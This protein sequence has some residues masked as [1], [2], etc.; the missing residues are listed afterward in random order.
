MKTWLFR[1]AAGGHPKLVGLEGGRFRARVVGGSRKGRTSPTMR[2][3][4]YL[5]DERAR[6][7]IDLG[8]ASPKN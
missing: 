8:G 1:C 3:A 6:G 4:I 7:N 5:R 2:V